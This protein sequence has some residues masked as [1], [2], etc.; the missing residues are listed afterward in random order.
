MV[1]KKIDYLN[2]IRALKRPT[3]GQSIWMG[4][5]LVIA[6]AL[7]I[8]LSNFVAC[9]RLTAL[10]G[11]P[12]SSCPGQTPG[13]VTNPEGTP[14][15]AATTAV[16]SI[17]APQGELPLA[18]DGASRVTILFIGLD[19]RDWVT[20][21]SAPRSDTMILLTIDPLTK[22]G[23]MLSI[24]RDMW[25][26]I[27]GFGYN[28]INGAYA[29]GAGYSLPG[30][31]PGLAMKTVENFLGIPINYYARV[32]FQTFEKMVDTIGGIDINVPAEIVIDP[33]GPHN[34]TTLQPGWNHLTGP[35]ALAYARARDESQGVSG[36][37]VERA[38][39]QQKVILA[40]R[41]KVLAAGN[42]LNLMAQAP[43]LYIELS[44][45]IDT[46][47]SLNDAMRLAVFAKDISLENIQNEVID[48]T[49]MQDGMVTLNGVK[50]AILRP[51]PDK[52]RELVDKVFGSGTMQPMAVGTI[53]EKMKAEAAR[54]V[55]INGSGVEGMAAR[56]SDYLKTQGMNVSGFGNTS[57][58]PDLYF[59]PFPYQTIIIVHAGKPYAMQYLLSLI[60]YNS[61]SQIKVD[62]NPDAPEDIIMALGSD[63]SGPP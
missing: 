16:P 32:D 53:E 50:S 35:L 28:R 38:Q 6:I 60:Q 48:Y 43:T 61:S 45:G 42:F 54:V 49:M 37:D 2:K 20:D 34:T 24:P 4:V 27:P 40:I 12:P 9:W 31:G 51:Y 5:G 36:G 1:E 56:T 62:F 17:S 7:Y 58:Y 39:N 15:A 10:A 14:V 19:Y 11:I 55:V 46:N 25:V 3:I 29:F 13:P 57:D 18:W 59:S 44:G 22:T 21:Q 23:G 41:D 8:F 52:I 30:G 63:W 33:L 26:N 47:L